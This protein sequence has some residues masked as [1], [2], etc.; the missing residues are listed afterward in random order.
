MNAGEILK[1]NLRCVQPENRL[2]NP[3]SVVQLH[4][5]PLY[6]QVGQTVE[7]GNAKTASCISGI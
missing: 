7:P 6:G 5:C 3:W 4:P 2:L 1:F